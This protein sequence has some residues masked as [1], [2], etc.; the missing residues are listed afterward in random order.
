MSIEC[1]LRLAMLK[2]YALEKPKHVRFKVLAPLYAPVTLKDP[3]SATEGRVDTTAPLTTK[4]NSNQPPATSAVALA[5][6]EVKED[7]GYGNPGFD[8]ERPQCTGL[9]ENIAILP[10]LPEPPGFV[11]IEQNGRTTKNLI[12]NGDYI[13]YYMYV[14]CL[15]MY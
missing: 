8:I 6:A 7:Q 15:I 9:R 11:W 1:N 10:T 14:N 4:L 2:R 5:D 3:V 13:N 12:A